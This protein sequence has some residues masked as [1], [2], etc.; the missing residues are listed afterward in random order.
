MDYINLYSDYY[1]KESLAMAYAQPV[2]PVGDVADWEV[3][4]EI[5]KMHVYLPVEAPPPSHRKELRIP[6]TGE[7]VNQRTVRC[8][9]CNE[10]GHNRKRCKNFI[11]SS[12]S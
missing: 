12:R 8:E 3:S 10:S 6:S 1:T 4:D 2:E 5:Q 9:R 11:A 7:D